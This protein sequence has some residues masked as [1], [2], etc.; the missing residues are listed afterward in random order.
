MS[1]ELT[2]SAETPPTPQSAKGA[3]RELPCYVSLEVCLK[4]LPLNLLYNILI[5]PHLTP[6]HAFH[7]YNP[8]QTLKHSHNH[9]FPK[10][11]VLLNNNL[12]LNSCKHSNFNLSTDFLSLNVEGIALHQSIVKEAFSFQLKFDVRAD[13]P[14]I[15]WQFIP[16]IYSFIK[17]GFKK[18]IVAVCS[19]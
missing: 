7:S 14:Y 13:F 9:S 3:T 12:Q 5:V 19:L 4:G 17:E 11:Y 1:A 16:C 6:F 18:L 15:Q 10:H 8:F 2:R